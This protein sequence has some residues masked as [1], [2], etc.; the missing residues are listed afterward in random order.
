[1]SLKLVL[2]VLFSFKLLASPCLVEK[3]FVNEAKSSLTKKFDYKLLSQVNWTDLKKEFSALKENT[4]R[5]RLCQRE[6]SQFMDSCR[7]KVNLLE[8]EYENIQVAFTEAAM[9]D[10]GFQ[11]TCNFYS[12]K[13]FKYYINKETKKIILTDINGLLG[14]RSYLDCRLD[15]EIETNRRVNFSKKRSGEKYSKFTVIDDWLYPDTRPDQYG[16]YPLGIQAL[17]SEKIRIKVSHNKIRLSLGQNYLDIENELGKIIGSNFIETSFFDNG[18][19]STSIEKKTKKL[20]PNFKFIGNKNF[21]TKI[22]SY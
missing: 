9:L 14:L 7:F 12:S 8:N 2:P 22:I 4:E 15:D 13:L 18:R 3:D 6:N 16:E 20:I 10:D 21:K 1:V 5:L 19:C 17:S 11:S